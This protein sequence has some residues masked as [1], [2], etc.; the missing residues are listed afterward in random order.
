MLDAPLETPLGEALIQLDGVSRRY[1]MGAEQIYALRDVSFNI[2]K[3]EY[4]GIIGQSGSG[5]STMLNILGAL[6]I[7]TAIACRRFFTFLRDLPIWRS[8]S[9]YSCITS[10]TLLRCLLLGMRH[11]L[12]PLVSFLQQRHTRRCSAG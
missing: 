11:L 12:K 4:V 5:K 9:L 8:P 10:R 3:G 6:D 2:R 7:A 1:D